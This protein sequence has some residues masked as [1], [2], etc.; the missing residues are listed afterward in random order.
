[1]QYSN[2]PIRVFNRC[3]SAIGV[4]A[5]FGLL[6]SGCGKPQVDPQDGKT[7]VQ[8]TTTS[9]TTSGTAQ[10]D[11]NTTTSGK[12]Q[13]DPNTTTSG[14]AQVDPQ[15]EDGNTVKVDDWVYQPSQIDYDGSPVT[16][17]TMMS[18]GKSLAEFSLADA[19]SADLGFAVGGANDVN[20]FRQ[21]VENGYLPSPADISHEG[22]FYDYFFDTG[23]GQACVELFCPSYSTAVSA[24]PFSRQAEYFLSV[25]LNS[26]I[27]ADD[28]ERKKLNLVVV[29]DIS[30]SMSS[31]FD[32]YY[33]DRS[34]I[35]PPNKPP[36]QPFG[37]D[38]S[39]GDQ[40]DS[41][42]SKMEVATRS[43]VA[44]LDHLGPDDRLGVVLFDD[45]AHVAKELRLVAETDMKAIKDHVLE[46]TPQGG[47][48]ME[49]GYEAGT[50]LFD[51]YRQ[52][53]REEYE[54]RIIFLTDAMPNTGNLS[55]TDLA[56]LAADNAEAGIYTSFIGIGVDFNAELVRAITRTQ[57]ANYFSVHSS[58]EF[59][60]QLDEGFEYMVT[61]LVFDLTLEL[62]AD[63]Y[64][65]KA[66]YGSPEADLASG[67]IMKVNTLFPSLRVDDQTRGGLVLLHLDKVADQA[68]LTLTVS[69]RDRTGQQHQNRQTVDLPTS[70][71]THF[72]NS[73][74]R[75]GIVLSRLVNVMQA[76]LQ[77]ESSLPEPVIPI[78]FV[79]YQEKGIPIIID[80]EIRLS[81]WE[82]TSRPLRLTD[83]YKP[84][85]TDLREYLA[86]ELPSVDDD[87]LLQEL[88]LLDLILASS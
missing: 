53:D 25:G 88:N 47:T 7:T 51:Q 34:P 9:T 65:I 55:K 75:K 69:Y 45:S 85:I 73:G 44:L 49:A 41:S 24:D 78:P 26:N 8:D 61:P 46:L 42:A 14:T 80:D 70:D 40:L 72:A 52:V 71:E 16:T 10:V 19:G 68:D 60:Q 30:G 57:G 27:K 13:V 79:Y 54:N 4:L 3:F 1:M 28:F 2:P 39:Q 6:V 86:Q 35:Q 77:H 63:G 29:L 62:E 37:V 11:P 17:M 76:W 33:Y 48:N 31:S 58:Y 22:I 12:P 74:I 23:A 5:V 59:Q 32:S 81:Y 82:R 18:P 87:T 50:G 56:D 43:L 84:I 20:N 36:D 66:V 83:T 21:N 38:P 15:D 64:D 67:E